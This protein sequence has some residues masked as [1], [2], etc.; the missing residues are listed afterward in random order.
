[1]QTHGLEIHLEPLLICAAA[2][3]TIQN[4]SHQGP[5]LLGAMDQVA[6]PVYVVF[7]T[8]AGARLDLGAL[9]ASWG[10]AVALAGFR[11]VMIML[12]T[13]LATS[14]AGDPAPFR[15]YCWLG[16][17]TQAGLS[18]ALI[19]QIESRFPDWG[20][21]LATTLVAVIAINQLIGPAAFKMALEKVGEA[22]KG[23][24]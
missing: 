10:L 1:M 21:G 7:F 20:P 12:G 13:R 11:I 5:R 14:L 23:T 18:L 22:R 17:V 3:F 4:W 24:S 19:S 2:G 16:F 15:R 9:A 6:L 8:M